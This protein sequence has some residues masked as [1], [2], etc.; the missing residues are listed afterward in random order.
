MT[1]H[2]TPEE[3]VEGFSQLHTLPEVYLRI[4]A[5]ADDP[6]SQANDLVRE[7]SMDP[8]LTARV[9][10]VVNSPLYGMNGKVETLLSAVS[11]L[12]T[13]AIHDLVLATSVTGMLVRRTVGELDLRDHWRLSLTIGLLAR[14]IAQSLRLLDKDRMFV[15]GLLSRMG[16]VVIH[17]RIGAVAR[18]VYRH[19]QTKGLP[20]HHSQRNFLG[21]HYGEVGAALLRRWRLPEQICNGIDRYL[22]PSQAG[23]A[24]DIAILRLAANL[25]SSMGER[26]DEEVLNDIVP[27]AGLDLNA[28]RL[29]EIMDT[30]R[31]ELET[32]LQ[33]VI[34]AAISAA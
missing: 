6:K 18:V 5:I 13:R 25:A 17:E 33:V 8:A 23:E 29:V 32:V 31:E 7:L 21:C 28:A 20:L 26:P 10:R 12:G 22:E 15:E 1:K 3:L 16:E 30:S 9:L 14:A 19:A 2:Y 27:T 4:K 34:P 11:V 24:A